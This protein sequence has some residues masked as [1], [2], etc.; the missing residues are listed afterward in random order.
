[1]SILECNG[2]KIVV[3]EVKDEEIMDLFFEDE[4]GEDNEQI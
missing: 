1:M 4:I 3:E 2:K